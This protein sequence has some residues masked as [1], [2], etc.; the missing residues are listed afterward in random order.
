M[1][2]ILI[3]AEHIQMEMIS[4]LKHHHILDLKN[5]PF[6]ICQK[7]N[8]LMS[9][10]RRK[11]R[12]EQALFTNAL[13]YVKATVFPPQMVDGMIVKATE[14]DLNSVADQDRN[15]RANNAMAIV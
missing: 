12:H 10:L 4:V 8:I 1:R 9:I 3:V 5:T 6:I 13:N 15:Q 2:V 7:N 11:L 14:K